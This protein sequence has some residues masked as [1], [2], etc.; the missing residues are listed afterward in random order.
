MFNQIIFSTQVKILE[1]SPVLETKKRKNTPGAVAGCKAIKT[2]AICC[3]FRKP[4]GVTYAS[5]QGFT[6]FGI[7]IEG[8][9]VNLKY[10]GCNYRHLNLPKIV[11][12]ITDL[13]FLQAASWIL[14]SEADLWHIGKSKFCLKKVVHVVIQY[15][16]F[17][18]IVLG[19]SQ[20]THKFSM[21]VY[22]AS[23]CLP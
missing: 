19:G 13:A 23:L 14:V 22:L 12:W 15:S 7:Y 11:K 20:Q 3:Y 16:K 2:M 21:F 9:A 1:N 6:L 4:I 5:P 8:K 18:Y 17:S 10:S